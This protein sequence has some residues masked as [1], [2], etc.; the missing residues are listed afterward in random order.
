VLQFQDRG[1]LSERC[2][3]GRQSPGRRRTKTVGVSG[4]G[5][6]SGAWVYSRSR[7]DGDQ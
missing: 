2:G 3:N 6:Q 7:L 4:G 1:C 5:C